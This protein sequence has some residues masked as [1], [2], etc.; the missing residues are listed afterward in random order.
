MLP[1]RGSGSVLYASGTSTV[2][3]L[4]LA[5]LQAFHMRCQRRILGVRWQDYVTNK[6]IHK[7][8]SQPHIGQLIQA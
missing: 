2:K 1:E 6:A 4:D 7:R 5:H 3:K 8:T